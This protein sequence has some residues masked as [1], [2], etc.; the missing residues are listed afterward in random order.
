EAAATAQVEATA[1]EATAEVEPAAVVS[2][3]SRVSEVS[4]VAGVS[5][6]SGVSLEVVHGELVRESGRSAR[7]R[8]RRHGVA[9]WRRKSPT[10]LR[11]HN[12]RHPARQG[13][14]QRHRQ[15]GLKNKLS[16]MLLPPVELWHRSL[17]RAAS[18]PAAPNAGN[19]S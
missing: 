13:R 6:I 18:F 10:R 16:H 7:L 9:E 4:G 2:E 5:G 3:V 19:T 15:A 1:V 17:P 8:E 14:G 11:P 12:A